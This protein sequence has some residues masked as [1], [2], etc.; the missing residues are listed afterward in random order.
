[1]LVPALAFL[2]AVAPELIPLL[3]GNQWQQ[4]IAPTQILSIAGMALSLQSG[5]EPLVMAMGRSGS[6]F[7]FNAVFLCGYAVV[8]LIAIPSG[9]ITICW[10]VAACHVAMLALSQVWLMGR[11]AGI[12]FGQLLLDARAGIVGTGALLFVT[13]PLSQALRGAHVTPVVIV[14]VCA[15]I[16]SATYLS[17]LRVIFPRVWRDL[18]LLSSTILRRPQLTGA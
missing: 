1:V 18:T 3:Y 17:V 2:I 14:V 9:L 15:L 7:A 16:A 6:L 5:A 12:G 11:I 4:A 10:A 8:L 13:L